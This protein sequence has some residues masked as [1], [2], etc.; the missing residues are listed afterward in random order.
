MTEQYVLLTT[1]SQAT[2]ECSEDQKHYHHLSTGHVES[3]TQHHAPEAVCS[4][5][6][7]RATY[8]EVL[9]QCIVKAFT[10]RNCKL[11][12]LALMLALAT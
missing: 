2:H 6:P 12:A 7:G 8:L 10:Q 1:C 5:S 11:S 3:A 9:G 4:G